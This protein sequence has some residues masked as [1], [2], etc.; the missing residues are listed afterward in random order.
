MRQEQQP[1]VLVTCTDHSR[2]HTVSQITAP[3]LG[4]TRLA[5]I[6][7]YCTCPKQDQAG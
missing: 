3:A 5:S 7:D 6:T 4:K 2:S 1:A